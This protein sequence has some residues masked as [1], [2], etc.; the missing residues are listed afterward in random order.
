MSYEFSDR[1]ILKGELLKY[2][3]C[4]C[5]ETARRGKKCEDCSAFLKDVNKCIVGL[6]IKKVDA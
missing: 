3:R 6:M 2:R 5:E 4:L 1:I